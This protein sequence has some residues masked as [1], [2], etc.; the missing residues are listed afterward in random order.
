[1][2]ELHWSLLAMTAVEL[3]A[4]KEQM[5]APGTTC[6]SRKQLYDLAKRSLAQA[7]QAIHGCLRDR[8]DVPVPGKELE[9][10]LATCARVRGPN[11]GGTQATLARDA[12]REKTESAGT[13]RPSSQVRSPTADKSRSPR[14]M[15]FGDRASFHVAL[16]SRKKRKTGIGSIGV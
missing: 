7:A 10:M 11:P 12:P 6:R 9:A 8:E 4:L 16:R 5:A 1:M 13:M 14:T 3:S 15:V 2:V